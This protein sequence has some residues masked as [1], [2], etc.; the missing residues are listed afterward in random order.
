[1]YTVIDEKLA[2]PFKTTV[3]GIEVVVKSVDQG[4]D[5]SIVAICARGRERQRIAIEDLPLPEPA[6]K[7]A[8]WIAAYRHWLEQM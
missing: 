5:D 7:G 2:M 1:L 3:L 4:I 6:P 8:K